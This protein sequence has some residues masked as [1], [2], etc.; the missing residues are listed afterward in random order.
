MSKE[1]GEHVFWGTRMSKE[2]GEHVFWGTR[3][4]KEGGEQRGRGVKGGIEVERVCGHRDTRTD[5]G[6]E[7]SHVV[8]SNIVVL[9]KLGNNGCVVGAGLKDPN[10]VKEG[11]A[12]AQVWQ[13][14][15]TPQRPGSTQATSVPMARWS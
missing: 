12:T 6:Q 13:P 15:T 8:W 9:G 5:L 1:G 4:S 3:M 10:M 14:H 2:G 11:V 7:S